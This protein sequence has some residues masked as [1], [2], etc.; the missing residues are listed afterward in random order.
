MT[1]FTPTVFVVDDEQDVRDSLQELVETIGLP[2]EC[3]ASAEDFL[4]AVE[5]PRPGA[6][7]LDIR[8]PGMS[9]LELQRRLNSIARFLPV[10]I[11][12]GHGSVQMSVQAMRQ[13]AFD[14]LEKPY[15][16]QQLLRVVRAAVDKARTQWQAWQVHEQLTSRIAT[17]SSRERQV[18]DLLVKGGE[19]RQIASALD[20]S[21][22]TV[23][24]HRLKVFHKIGVNSVPL[25]IREF[26][27]LLT[28]EEPP[29][30]S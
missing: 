11:V 18:C 13:G 6:V 5:P 16:T 29:E 7:I 21:P 10:V 14:F 19:T 8:M 24:K 4:E 17:L 15:D 3:F 30:Q 28:V 9:G 1:E 26:D 22:S 25:L 12:T 23:E 2:V 27:K 20:I